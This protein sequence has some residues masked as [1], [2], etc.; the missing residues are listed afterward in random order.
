MSRVFNFSAGPAALPEAVLQRAA[1]EMLD[2]QGAGCGVMEMSHR[3]KAF[4]RIVE[5]AEADFRALLKVPDTYKVLFLQGGATLQFSQLPMNLL[6][7]GSADYLVTGTWS[8]KAFNDAVRIARHIGGEIRL[9]GSTINHEVGRVVPHAEMSLGPGARYVHLCT[10]ETIHGIEIQDESQLPHT[11]VPLVADMSSHI[12]SREIDV[13]R[14]GLIYAG[15]QKNIGPSGLV[16]V[17]VRED[18][19][20]HAWAGTPPVM[21]YKVMADNGSMLNTPPTYAIYMAGLVFEWLLEQGG[22]SAIEKINADKAQRLYGFIDQSDFYFNSVDA[23][24]RS[25]MNIPFKLADE[26]LNE[27]FLSGAEVAG[28]TQLKGHKT[29]GGMRASLYNAMPLAGVE[30]LIAYMRDF[31]SRHG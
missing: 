31:V 25:R 16:I 1:D 23:G 18:L 27:A 8:Q 26:S 5:R 13:S 19:L 29:V 15:A 20:G 14:Y 9:A 12:L 30:S 2:W 10:N 22:V 11:A 21:D 6:A 4:T 7:G 3:G 17:I 24:S 28:L